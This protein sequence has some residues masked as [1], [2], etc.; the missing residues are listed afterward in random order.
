M[1]RKTNVYTFYS[2]ATVTG[3]VNSTGFDLSEYAELLVAVSV[4]SASGT[5]D[6]T[7]Q[8]S[9][10]NSTWFD[11]TSMSQI[12]STGEYLSK[13]TNVGKY[14]RLK[15]ALGGSSP[16]FTLSAWGVAKS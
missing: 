11:H 4:T 9:P 14:V 8:T 3:D 10:D 5:L 12:S 2:S 7:V 15:L 1:A 16:S 6:I 13:L